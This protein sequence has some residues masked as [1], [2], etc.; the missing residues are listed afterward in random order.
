MRLSAVTHEGEI[1]FL[2]GIKFAVFHQGF[3]IDPEA[4]LASSAL[5][6]PPLQFRTDAET[7]RAAGAA[8]LD[9]HMIIGRHAGNLSHTHPSCNKKLWLWSRRVLA[10]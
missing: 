9:L 2:A 10:D 3:V 4:V 8:Y 6:H 5:H 7:L 1:A